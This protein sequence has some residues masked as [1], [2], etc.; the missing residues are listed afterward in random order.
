LTAISLLV[1]LVLLAMMIA[2]GVLPPCV[3]RAPVEGMFEQV[4][5]QVAADVIMTA[6]INK[7][8][9]QRPLPGPVGQGQCSFELNKQLTHCQTMLSTDTSH[10]IIKVRGLPPEVNDLLHCSMATDRS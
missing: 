1:L 3:A 9:Q 10:H 8:T 7:T 4:Q 5:L 2:P 6:A